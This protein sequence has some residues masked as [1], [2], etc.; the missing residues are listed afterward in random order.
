MVANFCL[1]APKYVFGPNF[2]SPWSTI[3]H[4]PF[5]TSAISNRD[6]DVTYVTISHDD[7]P[8]DVKSARR[9]VGWLWAWDDEEFFR[10]WRQP[11]DSQGEL[12]NHLEPRN[13]NSL[14]EIVP[15][16][17]ADIYDGV[18]LVTGPDEFGRCFSQ[19][20]LADRLQP[21]ML[22][23]N[24]DAEAAVHCSW[25]PLTPSGDPTGRGRLLAIAQHA[26]KAGIL[27]DAIVKILRQYAEQQGFSCEYL[28]DRLS[29][30]VL[31]ADP[32]WWKDSTPLSKRTEYYGR[33]YSDQ[34]QL[35]G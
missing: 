25:Y 18:C 35:C 3:M 34:P 10:R 14:D 33:L 13:W 8:V 9:W 12:I 5:T 26:V 32:S 4:L 23:E 11:V 27:D 29:T 7:I 6:V 2:P 20:E 31:D 28:D 30:I 17:D 19:I 16:L 24:F 15:L 21:R 1:V 22:P